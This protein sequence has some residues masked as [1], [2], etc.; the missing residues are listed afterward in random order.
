MP[1]RPQQQAGLRGRGPGSSSPA[2]RSPVLTGASG[3]WP[4]AGAGPGRR[5]RSSG[6]RRR[7]DLRP[8][9]DNRC[10]EVASSEEDAPGGQPRQPGAGGGHSYPTGQSPRNRRYR[11]P[12]LP[13]GPVRR[14]W[15]GAG[16]PRPRPGWPRQATRSPGVQS[17]SSDWASSSVEGILDGTETWERR[18]WRRRRSAS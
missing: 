15:P 11:G 14:I 5:A 9:R 7:I 4:T 2:E 3:W 10:P 16:G 6:R 13:R 8:T 12:A 1:K 18:R 17:A